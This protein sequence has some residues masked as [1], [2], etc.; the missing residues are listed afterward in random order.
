M[1]NLYSDIEIILVG[2]IRSETENVLKEYSKLFPDSIKI[3]MTWS[4]EKEE[5]LYGFT[6]INLSDIGSLN[7]F[8]LKTKNIRRQLLLS[9]H[10]KPKSRWMLRGRSDIMP[11]KSIMEDINNFKKNEDREYTFL[12]DGYINSE[13]PYFF[14]DFFI[15]GLSNEVTK[16]YLNA[17]NN[18]DQLIQYP[19]IVKT[20][21]ELNKEW[22]VQ[23]TYDEL[24]TPEFLIN[25]FG[26]YQH[27]I[28]DL[29]EIKEH[30]KNW[31]R[32]K[33]LFKK[34]DV[35]HFIYPKPL[36]PSTLRNKL[37][38]WR[39]RISKYRKISSIINKIYKIRS[40]K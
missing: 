21:K 26:T 28:C 1:K 15:F 10:Y 20:L 12:V 39:Y 7:G 19:D 27:N 6:R 30:F 9:S 3:L 40:K 25:F 2:P 34:I 13:A 37:L 38:R 24:L 18:V 8:G 33:H 29:I 22:E 35:K 14:S 23:K 11:K 31:Q 4:N 32:N 17:K 36:D 16:F 5:K